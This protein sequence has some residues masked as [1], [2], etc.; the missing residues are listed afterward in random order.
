MSVAA[1]SASDRPFH[2]SNVLVASLALYNAFPAD[3][4]QCLDPGGQLLADVRLPVPA[5]I[6][7]YYW[8]PSDELEAGLGLPVLSTA[9]S[10]CRS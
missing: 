5:P 10:S 2:Q 7:F 6:V 8:R 1:G 3:G 4:P 9:G